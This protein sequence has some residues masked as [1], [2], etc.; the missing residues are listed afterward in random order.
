MNN[1]PQLPRDPAP[2]LESVR[3]EWGGHEDLWVFAYASLIWRPDFDYAER[4]PAKVHG[5]HRA[6]KMWSRVN[7]GTPEC[8][9]LV[10]GMLS[11]G[12]CRGMVY[13]IPRHDGDAVLGV[14]WGREMVSG[15]Y[16]PR[17]LT[18]HTPH[19]PV[20]AL[21]FTLSRKSP[22]HTG[23]LSEEEYRRIFSASCGRYGTTLDYARRTL[24][25][26]QRHNI[27]D[28]HLERLLRLGGQAQNG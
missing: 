19:G 2:M 6:L 24:E 12:S 10:F 20:Q 22:S 15:V 7:R 9:G 3:R 18:C 17:W 1:P 26:L 14:L 21:A 13:R 8:P 25:E 4:R 16:D 28:R 23:V 5:W 11:G 27:R